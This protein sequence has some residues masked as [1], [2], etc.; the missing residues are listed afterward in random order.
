[1]IKSSLLIANEVT[2]KLGVDTIMLL[3]V[4]R[5]R[6]FNKNKNIWIVLKTKAVIVFNLEFDY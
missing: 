4:T 5:D 1:M 6:Y 3:F 2:R